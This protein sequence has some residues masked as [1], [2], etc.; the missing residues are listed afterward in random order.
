MENP[1]Y[2]PGTTP[3]YSNAAYQVLSYALE[4]ITGKTFETMFAES[5]LN[6]LNLNA[7]SLTQPNSTADAIIP[8]NETASEWNYDLGDGA[9]CVPAPY[10]YSKSDHR[11]Y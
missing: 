11:T 1:S 2:A 8:F 10:L 4:A 9:A 3:A 5:I 7:T 6:P